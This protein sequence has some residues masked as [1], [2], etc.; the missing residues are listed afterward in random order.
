[1]IG[2]RRRDCIG[3]WSAAVVVSLAWTIPAVG[4]GD[5]TVSATP[6]GGLWYSSGS[7]VQD[8]VTWV[9]GGAEGSALL[10]LRSPRQGW[11]DWV[12]L[13]GKS[14][15]LRAPGCEKQTV[16]HTPG[17]YVRSRRYTEWGDAAEMDRQALNESLLRVRDIWGAL[18]TP[19]LIGPG[20]DETS[21]GRQAAALWEA[22]QA[23]DKAG[24]TLRVEGDYSNGYVVAQNPPGGWPVQPGDVVLVWLDGEEVRD[25]ADMVPLPGD[26]ADHALPIGAD[27]HEIHA[28]VT[29]YHTDSVDTQVCDGDG[30]EIVWKLPD[31]IEGAN[32]QVSRVH[33]DGKRI[34]LSAWKDDSTSNP[35]KLSALGCE[36]NATCC[37]YGRDPTLEFTA[38]ANGGCYIV[39]DLS[40]E[41]TGTIWLQVLWEAATDAGRQEQSPRQE[42]SK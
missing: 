13:H 38:P 4:N 9:E 34:T 30:K 1:M 7:A 8:D 39:A 42:K 11:T 41:D 28:T 27:E 18:H 16:T 2:A 35:V 33:L 32:V 22:Q 21:N 37:A 25:P 23:L 6:W 29:R 12:F 36:G 20:W 3:V 40:D 19:F 5:G 14:M 31:G 15:Y 24:L 17:V 26:D 10:L